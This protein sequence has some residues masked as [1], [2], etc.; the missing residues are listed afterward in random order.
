[1]TVRPLQSEDLEVLRPL[2]RAYAADA[3]VEPL[4]DEGSLSFFGRTGHSF[5]L[6]RSGEPSGFLLAQSVWDG[7]RPTVS[8][9]RFA[10]QPDSGLVALLE[11]LTKSAYDAG[12]YDIVAAVPEVDA[13][14]REA[15][16]RSD[17]RL[18]R[19]VVYSR[20]LGSRSREGQ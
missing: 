20:V 15:L 6:E 5:V 3:G 1:M 13:P 18:R 19:N 16:E 10:A 2:D 9:V 4:L 14:G 7:K 11:A 17:Y 12:V 8:I